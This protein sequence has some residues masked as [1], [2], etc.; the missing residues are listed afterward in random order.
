MDADST[1]EPKYTKFRTT[2]ES[3]YDVAIASVSPKG[4]VGLGLTANGSVK[5]QNWP[6]EFVSLGRH[7]EY[8]WA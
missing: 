7:K 2:I 4:E 6:S 1:H 3:G 5:S 8:T